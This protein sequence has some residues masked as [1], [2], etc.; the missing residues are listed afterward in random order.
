M[1][2]ENEVKI[3]NKDA[4]FYAGKMVMM[5]QNEIHLLARGRKISVLFDTI[6]KFKKMA[7]KTNDDIDV[8]VVSNTIEIDTERGKKNITDLEVVLNIK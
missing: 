5:K 7:N 2:E 3:G 4:T 6:E 1:S 8:S